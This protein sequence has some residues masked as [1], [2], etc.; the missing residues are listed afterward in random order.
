MIPRTLPAIAVGDRVAVRVES[1]THYVRGVD[2]EPD[3]PAEAL[4][5]GIA[6]DDALRTL[7]HPSGGTRS[8]FGPDAFVAG[9]ER[10]ERLV[11]WPLGIARAGAMRQWG[12]HA[13]A[14]I[15]RRH[16]DEPFL[17]DRYFLP[18]R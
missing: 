3:V 7:A 16:F 4:R 8:L 6:P 18:A 11:F 5:Y 1:G 13:T 10:T 17:L 9:T 12:H 15:G 14:F 2:A